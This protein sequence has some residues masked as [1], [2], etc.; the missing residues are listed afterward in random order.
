[1]GIPRNKEAAKKADTAEKVEMVSHLI[2]PVEFGRR[3]SRVLH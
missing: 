2:R 1:M 3:S